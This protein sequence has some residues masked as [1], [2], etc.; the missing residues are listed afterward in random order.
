[1]INVTLVPAS[2]LTCPSV[3]ISICVFSFPSLISL[4]VRGKSEI[5]GPQAT[6]K[7]SAS[8][9]CAIKFPKI[10]AGNIA[11]K[12]NKVR[13]E[14]SDAL[15]ICK[16]HEKKKHETQNGNPHFQVFPTDTRAATSRHRRR[17]EQ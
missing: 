13:K 17:G 11:A 14:W 15:M 6:V 5:W 8:P 7:H 2:R 12:Q 10:S 3:M 16:L 1:M 9:G 4:E